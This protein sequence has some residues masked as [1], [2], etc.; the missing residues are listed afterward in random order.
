VSV[1]LTQQGNLQLQTFQQWIALMKQYGGT[2]D[3]YQQQ[4]SGDQQALT[5]A[6]SDATFQAALSTLNGHVTAIKLPALK[7]EAYGLQQQLSQEST[8]WSNQHTYY[9]SYDGVTY[10]LGYEYEGIVNYPAQGLLDSSQTVADY[11]Y[12]IGQLDNW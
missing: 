9:D 3:Q 6:S 7:A 10:N 4:Y 11:Q 8:A 1:T 5:S 12:I 2:V